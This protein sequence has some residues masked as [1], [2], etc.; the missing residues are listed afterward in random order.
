MDN[1]C[2]RI[3]G[4]MLAQRLNDKM[5]STNSSKLKLQPKN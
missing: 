5:L 3:Q 4:L 1:G 2:R